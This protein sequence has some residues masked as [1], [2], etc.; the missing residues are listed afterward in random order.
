MANISSPAITHRPAALDREASI[1]RCLFLPPPKKLSTPDLH[2]IIGLLL[3]ASTR[4]EK[5]IIGLHIMQGRPLK[6]VANAL[7]LPPE[8]VKELRDSLL[9]KEVLMRQQRARDIELAEL[10]EQG[11]A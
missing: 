6:H 9:A 1:E 3:L 2:R 8:R 7:M 11:A 5:W 10:A 4:A